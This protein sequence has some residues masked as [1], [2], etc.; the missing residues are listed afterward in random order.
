M[1]PLLPIYLLKP[2][3]R[4]RKYSSLKKHV[5]PGQLDGSSLTG[6]SPLVQKEEFSSTF[7]PAANESAAHL[8]PSAGTI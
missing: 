1:L 6:N 3:H 2:L 4:P 5:L 8:N 7:P